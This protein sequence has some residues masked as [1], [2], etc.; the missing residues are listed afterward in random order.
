MR[1]TF[2]M[3]NRPEI[4]GGTT[5]RTT[6]TGWPRIVY[7]PDKV[8][9]A[10]SV[11]LDKERAAWSPKRGDEQN[12]VTVAAYAGPPI[13]MAFRYGTRINQR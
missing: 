10:K 12:A 3:C 2:A 8:A 7:Q 5:T 6:G 9:I 1:I 4:A 13:S 11:L